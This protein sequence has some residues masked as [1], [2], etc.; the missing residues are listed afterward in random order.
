MPN[1]RGTTAIFLANF[2]MV[3]AFIRRLHVYFSALKIYMVLVN[4]DQ[5]HAVHASK[6]KIGT[7]EVVKTG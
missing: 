6:T 4:H 5:D 7:P 3:N 1:T 2:Y